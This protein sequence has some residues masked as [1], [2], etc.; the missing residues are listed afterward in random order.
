MLSGICEVAKQVFGVPVRVGYPRGV[1]ELEGDLSHPMY[2]GAVGL[3]YFAGRD[4]RSRRSQ[5]SPTA[6][7][8]ANTCW[9]ISGRMKQWFAE[10]F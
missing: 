10:A 1:S 4:N 3:V 6:G 5:K 2:A 7:A 8:V 9:G